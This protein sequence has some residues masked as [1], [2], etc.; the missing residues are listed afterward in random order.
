M[1]SVFMR[2]PEGKAK[3][4]TFSYDD[5]VKQDE[6]LAKIF[7]KYG[8]KATFNLCSSVSRSENFSDEEL[9]R[10]RANWQPREPKITTGYLARYASL[11]TSGNKGA[12]LEHK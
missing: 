1:I 5:G 9:E 6:R 7:D 8:M 10:R 12:I 3:A 2:Y 4:V 11:V